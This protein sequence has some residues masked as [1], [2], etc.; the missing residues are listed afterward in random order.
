MVAYWRCVGL[1]DHTAVNGAGRIE[2]VFPVNGAYGS[3]RV[4]MK[5]SVGQGGNLNFTELKCTL[6]LMVVLNGLGS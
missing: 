2:A 6:Q 5:A 3:A 4:T 1:P